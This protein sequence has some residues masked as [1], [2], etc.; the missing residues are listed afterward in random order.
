MG[1]PHCV[2]VKFVH[3]DIENSTN[4][5]ITK[6]SFLCLSIG[7]GGEDVMLVVLAVIRDLD[8]WV[9]NSPR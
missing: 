7:G 8:D 6:T 5:T 1:F 2:E 4:K 9:S 3:K